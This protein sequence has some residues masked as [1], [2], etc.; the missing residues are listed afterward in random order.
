[1]LN[2]AL[3][4]LGSVDVRWSVVRAMREKSGKPDARDCGSFDETLD[5]KRLSFLLHLFKQ[6][7]SAYA[8]RV[9]IQILCAS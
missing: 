6:L 8:P 2:E 3:L 5:I 1:M 4:F 7:A 9:V